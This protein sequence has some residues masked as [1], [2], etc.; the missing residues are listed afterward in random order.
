[1]HMRK[2]AAL[3]AALVAG[4]A[5]HAS[6]PQWS[7]S[8]SFPFPSPPLTV[9][10]VAFADLDGD[11]RVEAILAGRGI[12]IAEGMDSGFGP[13]EKRDTNL[14][15]NAVASGDFDG[16]GRPDLVRGYTFPA[17]DRSAEIL[18]N[19]NG[20]LGDAQPL[21]AM[22]PARLLAA[23][24][25]GD[26]H[27]DIVAVSGSNE[28]VTA[29]GDG[30]GGF[31]PLI[32]T[33]IKALPTAVAAGDFNGDG[34]ADVA[35]GD[36]VFLGDGTGRFTQYATLSLGG[37]VS[38]L[39][40]G[41]FNGDRRVDL[42]AALG[43]GVAILTATGNGFRETARLATSD[44]S[45]IA[46]ADFDRNGADD[47][48]ILQKDGISIWMSAGDGAFRRAPDV[49][50]L[51]PQRIAALDATG[52]SNPDL[53]VTG[54]FAIDVL[55]GTGNGSFRQIDLQAGLPASFLA[56][57]DLDGDGDTDAVAVGIFYTLSFNS[58]AGIILRNEHGALVR[59]SLPGLDRF[60]TGMRLADL[61]GDGVPEILVAVY[62]SHTPSGVISTP[63]SIYVYRSHGTTILLDRK[64]D[65]P[66]TE[67]T[68][69]VTGDFDNDGRQDVA[70][71]TSEGNVDV[72]AFA[73]EPHVIGHVAIPEHAVPAGVGDIDRDGRMD[74]V[75][76]RPYSTSGAK[77]GFVTVLPGLGG[78]AFGSPI[79]VVDNAFVSRALVGDF[80]GDRRADI[81]VETL[82]TIEIAYSN[83]RTFDV[84]RSAKSDIDDL[85]QVADVD[86]DGHDDVLAVSEETDFAVLYMGGR[87]AGPA[88]I[89]RFAIPLGY[90]AT[91]TLGDF[92]GDGS[93]DI[94]STEDGALHH[95]VCGSTPRRRAR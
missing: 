43:D 41:D 48:A 81:I 50:T 72:V 30:A 55:P 39:A 62:G 51:F 74:L 78:G 33:G 53:V 59:Q 9:S 2:I 73:G 21:G 13:M 1:M 71:L 63:A 54:R 47:L 86:G 61:D 15:F 79:T 83:G 70:M 93:L 58:P 19:K 22:Q 95:G 37:T 11:G 57:G 91:F 10:D 87:A 88:R 75:L 27:A 49:K 17:L 20:K 42:A 28:I 94:L 52:D 77:D 32:H 5:A 24:L 7:V 25:N 34:R 92:D 67:E 8:T 3:A 80:D 26:R 46:V 56:T 85:R 84:R 64:L 40:T 44:A 31:G 38:A 82:D 16:D 4:A 68:Y 29:I 18:L 45:Q 76:L 12:Y 90:F 89:S 36:G 6:C 35:T 69:F 66:G 60:A 23:D 65:A 14:L